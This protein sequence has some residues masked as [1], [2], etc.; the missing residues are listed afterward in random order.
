MPFVSPRYIENLVTVRAIV[1]ERNAKIHVSEL[2]ALR[3][4]YPKE[5]IPFDTP[6]HSAWPESTVG[7]PGD[8]K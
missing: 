7:I 4:T 1:F 2:H 8:R 3:S 5:R 6:S